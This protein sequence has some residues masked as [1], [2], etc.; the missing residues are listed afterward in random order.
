MAR[1]LHEG[2][3]KDSP[4]LAALDAKCL[5]LRTQ[6]KI[7]AQTDDKTHAENQLTEKA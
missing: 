4:A 6:E 1:P 2:S 3:V 7:A 5:P